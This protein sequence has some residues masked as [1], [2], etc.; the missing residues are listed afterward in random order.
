MMINNG[1]TEDR[2]G[3]INGASCKYSTIMGYSSQRSPNTSV[4]RAQLGSSVDIFGQPIPMDARVALDSFGA[5]IYDSQ[6]FQILVD[7][8]GLPLFVD[9]RVSQQTCGQYASIANAYSS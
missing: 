1:N 2:T 9:S 5:P 3:S 4:V 8:A 7:R 6:G